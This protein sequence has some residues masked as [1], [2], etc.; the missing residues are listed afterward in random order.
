MKTR[1][2][3]TLPVVLAAC[4]SSEPVAICA[5]YGDLSGSVS[6]VL[7]TADGTQTALTYD[8]ATARSLLETTTRAESLVPDLWRMAETTMRALPEVESN[9]CGLDSISVVSVVF[10]DG[11]VTTRETSCTGNALH[12]V[13]SETFSASEV[14]RIVEV[15]IPVTEGVD[16]GPLETV[17]DACTRVQ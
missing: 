14:D 2:I 10:D 11:T 3:L 6:A 9:P 15:D 13:A 8:A 7:Q 5:A 17:V 12:R 4:Q 16:L 1:W